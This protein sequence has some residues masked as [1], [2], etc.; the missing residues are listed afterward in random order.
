MRG[1]CPTSERGRFTA[2]G[3]RRGAREAGG[4]SPLLHLVPPRKGY[5]ADSAAARVGHT[6]SLGKGVAVCA[7]VWCPLLPHHGALGS[8]PPL[9]PALILVTFFVNK[10]SKMTGKLDRLILPNPLK[11]IER[12]FNFNWV[13][14]RPK[15]GGDLR[16]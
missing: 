4:L 2:C 13:W 8:C 6:G 16:H 11:S 1:S 12:L 14:S 3:D 10:P 9:S 7:C 15:T 5:V